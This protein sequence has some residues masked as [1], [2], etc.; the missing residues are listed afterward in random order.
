MFLKEKF[1]LNGQKYCIYKPLFLYEVLAYFNT[2]N[3]I[4]IVEYNNK[5]CN[6]QE[7]LN[8]RIQNGDK[9]EIITIVG[10]G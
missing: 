7:L 2:Y 8:I 10:G 5:I 1:Y 4:S 3:I 9:L 6:Q